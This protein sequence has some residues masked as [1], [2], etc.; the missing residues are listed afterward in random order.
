[1]ERYVKTKTLGIRGAALHPKVLKTLLRK[2]TLI[3]RPGNQYTTINQKTV[4]NV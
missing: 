2:N 3:A 4:E 1:V